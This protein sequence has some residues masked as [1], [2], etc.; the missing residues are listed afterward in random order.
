MTDRLNYHKEYYKKNRNKMLQQNRERYNEKRR[1]YAVKI[2]DNFYCYKQKKDIEVKLVS[3]KD[4]KEH[5]NY[6]RMF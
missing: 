3:Y 6:I 4:I 5:P 2:G 1:Y